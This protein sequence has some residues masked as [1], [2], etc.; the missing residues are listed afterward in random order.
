MWQVIKDQRSIN[1][2][3]IGAARLKNNYQ[4]CITWCLG[5]AVLV[6]GQRK[7]L[8]K[9]LALAPSQR[10]RTSGRLNRRMVGEGEEREDTMCVE[11]LTEARRGQWGKKSWPWWDGSTPH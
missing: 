5:V 7:A 1:A 11:K 3:A 10:E 2:R 9:R 4:I 8:C 6:E